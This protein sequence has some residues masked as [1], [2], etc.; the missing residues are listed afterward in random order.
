MIGFILKKM[1]DYEMN[2]IKNKFE[3]IEINKQK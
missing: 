1:L 3:E 2:C